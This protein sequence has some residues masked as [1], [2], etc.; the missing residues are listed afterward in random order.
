MQKFSERCER[1][2]KMY[3]DLVISETYVEDF[4]S[5]KYRYGVEDEF[6]FADLDSFSFSQS[7]SKVP[8]VDQ[9]TDTSDLN[10]DIKEEISDLQISL[11]KA[12]IK[13]KSLYQ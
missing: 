6:K 9:G 8:M 13:K 1:V 11:P 10:I 3:S 12:K 7:I 5:L 2:D 4:I